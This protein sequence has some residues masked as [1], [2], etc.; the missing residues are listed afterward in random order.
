M[1]GGL[2][3]HLLDRATTGFDRHDRGWLLSH[4][5]GNYSTYLG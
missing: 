2:L 4:K 1:F 5:P 3:A